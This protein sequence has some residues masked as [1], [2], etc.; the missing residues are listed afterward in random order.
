[1]TYGELIAHTDK[2]DVSLA[3]GPG[4]AEINATGVT[5]LTNYGV[6][7]DEIDAARAQEAK[8]RAEEIIKSRSSE[9]DLALAQVELTRSLVELKLVSKRKG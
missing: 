4:F 3:I 7:S 9:M 1:M 2:G 8:A 6:S 5:V